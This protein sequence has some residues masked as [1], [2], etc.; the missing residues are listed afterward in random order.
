MGKEKLYTVLME[1]DEAKNTHTGSIVSKHGTWHVP[2]MDQGYETTMRVDTP[3]DIRNY[4]N[5][6]IMRWATAKGAAGYAKRMTKAAAHPWYFIPNGNYKVIKLKPVYAIKGYEW[7]KEVEC[8]G[9]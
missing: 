3:D 6:D 9:Q 1:S 4:L 2:Y 5:K 7:D 8:T